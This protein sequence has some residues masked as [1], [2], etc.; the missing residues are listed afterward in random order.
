VVRDAGGSIPPLTLVPT[1]GQ[2]RIRLRETENIPGVEA[3]APPDL[4]RRNVFVDTI[5]VPQAWQ[6]EA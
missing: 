2:L 6:S 3:S 1:A 5:V 4:A